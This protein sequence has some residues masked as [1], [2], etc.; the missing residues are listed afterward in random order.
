MARKY[1]GYPLLLLAML[2]TDLR[3][4]SFNEVSPN[5]K[6]LYSL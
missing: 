4:R 2:G 1:Y 3:K 5:E 6:G